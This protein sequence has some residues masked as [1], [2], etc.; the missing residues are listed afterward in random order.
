MR[1]T[2]NIILD[3]LVEY[4][5]QY[6]PG[7]QKD[8]W[9]EQIRLLGPDDIE[10]A[11]HAL[12]VCTDKQLRRSKL[13]SAGE[14]A[15]VCIGLD[16]TLADRPAVR[17]AG[18]FLIRQEMKCLAGLVNH[19]LEH[20]ALL[21]SWGRQLD[22]AILMQKD[23]QSLMD[24]C[25]PVFQDNL[26]LLWDSSYNLLAHSRAEAPNERLRKIVDQGFFSKDVTDDLAQMGY[27]KNAM[28]YSKPTFVDTPNYMNCPFILRTFT[29]AQRIQYA[30]IIYFNA[31]PPSWG[32]YDIFKFFS[33]RLAAYILHLVDATQLRESGRNSQCLVDLI[34]NGD[35]GEQ[36]LRDRAAVLGLKEK[37]TYHLCVIHFQEYTQEQAL[38]LR[39]R[40]RGIC[41][42][43][44]ASIYKKDLVFLFNMGETSLMNREAAL[45]RWQKIQTLLP[46]CKAQAAFGSPLSSYQDIGLAYHQAQAAMKCGR[47][48]HPDKTVY[49]YEEYYIYDMIDSY[50]QRF[51]LEKMYVQDL[52][53]LMDAKNYK[54]SNLYLLHTYLANERNIS[55]TAKALYMHRNSVIYRIARIREQLDIDFD[56]PDARLRL[57]IS[58]KILELADRAIFQDDGE[59]IRAGGEHPEG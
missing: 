37:C 52:V 49:Y 42:R 47:K 38:Y 10:A 3:W 5:V 44:V 13:K 57:L 48:L 56:D 9:V 34:E 20:K 45:E 8:L 51:P 19:L 2:M 4:D 23:F 50:S 6:R 26:S 22:E 31:S 12:Y 1:L 59:A 43:L 54:S 16:N 25:E 53:L 55:Q 36:Y 18:F 32:M 14:A 21:D 17:E 28:A 40:V 39:M 35:R 46:I 11:P 29:V 27:M 58:F 24:L 15:F 30:I 41:G 7:A 33:D